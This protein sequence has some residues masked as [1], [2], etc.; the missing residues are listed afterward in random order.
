MS[1]LTIIRDENKISVPFEVTPL[2]SELL[3]EQGIYL[4]SPCGG[5]GKCGKCAVKGEGRLS[6]AYSGEDTFLACKTRLYGDATV[7]IP[8]GGKFSILSDSTSTY[9][10]S[11]RFNYGAAVDVGTT[12]VVL[13][14]YSSCGECVGESSAVNPQRA[15]SA[16]VIGRISHSLN[17]GRGKL[18]EIIIDCISHLLNSACG[19]AGIHNTEVDRMVITGNTAM[20]YLLTGRNPVSI[21]RF[22]FKADCLFGEETELF[23]I[24]T[25]LTP[26]VSAFVG[27]DTVSALLA[28][29]MLCKDETAILCDMGTNGEIALYKDG[30]LYVTSVAAGP[31]FE[32]GEI[33]C[34]CAG[35]D[36]AVYR[37]WAEDGEIYSHTIGNMPAVGICGSGLIDVVSAFLQGGYIDTDGTVLRPPVIKAKG[38]DLCLNQEDIR[39]LQLAK[40]AVASGVECMLARSQ[41]HVSEVKALYLCGGFGSKI[42]VESAVNIGLFP[43]ELKN[44]VRFMGNGALN[45]AEK[46]L[47]DDSYCDFAKELAAKAKTLFLG[48]SKDFNQSFIK[49]MRFSEF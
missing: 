43:R 4:E 15:F 23:G 5:N 19:F 18:K 29:G 46:M 6:P 10:I 8:S 26:C 9:R 42:D 2:L 31:A 1:V 36:G 11:A 13:K 37:V 40:S 33:S 34:G 24:K 32:G 25:Y 39:A 28:S 17:G 14:L 7:H 41:T 22:P 21:S 45:G 20:L 48:G 30:S 27:G 38:K 44:K 35:T 49:N 3:K 12:T 47:F 16:D